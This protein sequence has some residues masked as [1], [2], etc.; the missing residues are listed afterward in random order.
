MAAKQK[1]TLKRV[2]KQLKKY[3]FYIVLTVFFALVTVAGSLATPVFFGQI[4]NLI[5][6]KG[7]VDFAK[8]FEKFIIIPASISITC[9][10]QSLMHI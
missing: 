4:V 3:K 10:E 2:L 5:I 9:V 8:I 7:N 6:G 1:G